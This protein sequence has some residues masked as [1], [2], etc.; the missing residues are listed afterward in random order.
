[1]VKHMAVTPDADSV[2][3]SARFT[4]KQREVLEQAAAILNCKPAKLIREASLQRAADVVNASG[5]AGTTLRTLARKALQPMINPLLEC[6][7]RGRSREIEDIVE[8]HTTSAW[9]AMEIYEQHHIADSHHDEPVYP[10]EM[11]A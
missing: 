2:T 8:Y 10:M 11:R 9:D 3:L 6:R 1:M 7:W 4:P 5:H